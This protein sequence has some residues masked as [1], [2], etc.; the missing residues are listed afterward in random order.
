[1]LDG[2][3]QP[4]TIFLLGLG[5]GFAIPL[6]YRLGAFW[7]HAGF[8][9]A[10]A[11]MAAVSCLLLATVLQT[12]Q[13]IEVLTAG[14]GPPF[15][16][17]LRFG[18][19]EGF[20][21][22]GVNIVAVLGAIHL[23]G[24]L[25]GNY[26]ALLLYLILTMG[27]AGMVMTRDLFNLFV[28]LEIVSIATYGLLGLGSDPRALAAGFK[29]IAAT[30]VASS[31]FLLGSVLLYYATGTLN[32]DELIARRAELGGVTAQTG[33]LLLLACL[34]IELKPFP[35]N[36]WG[37]DAYETAPSGIAAMMSV[38]VSAGVFFALFKLLPIFESQYG[39]IALCGGITFL[40]SNLLGLAQ[41]KV[42]RLFG[43]SSV[44]QMGLL[45]LA[46]VLLVQIGADGSLPLVVGG[47]FLNHLLAKAGLFWFAGIVG[48]VDVDGLPRS[49]PG[50]RL[51]AACGICVISISG[52][53]PFPAFWAKW[54]LVLQLTAAD[55]LGWVALIL[56]GS[57]FEAAYMFRWFARIA[58]PA[59]TQAAQP[60]GW[61]DSLPV[62]LVAALL[63]AAGYGAARLSGAGEAWLMVP[64]AAGGALYALDGLPS[65]VKGVVTL[66]AVL[67]LGLWLAGATDGIA[68]LF[69]Y[70]LLA[71]SL[72]IS[73]GSL[74]RNDLRPGY[75][76]LLAVLILSIVALLRASTSLQFFYS[77][78]VVTLASYFLIAKGRR[79]GPHVLPFLLF[80]LASA[81]LVL[82]G[83]AEMAAASGGTELAR[84][85]TGGPPANIALFLL[86]AGF[87]IKTAAVG[88]HVWLAGAYAE[89]DDDVTAMLSAVVSKVAII[90]LFVG[91]YLA[92][93][94]AA[95]LDAA[96]WLAWIGMLTTIAGALMAL[97]QAD[98]KR[99]LAFSS[100]SQ[101][102]YI[103]TAIALM[104]HLGWVTA[105]Y[106][107]ANHLMVKGILFLAIAGI[108]LR[109]GTR[110]FAE[111]GGLRRD[112]PVTFAMVLVAILSM[113]GL[114]P[115]MGFGA[116]WLLL[117]AMTD[118]GWTML[119]AAGLFATFLGFLYMARL[120][121]GLFLGERRPGQARAGEAPP[122]L[123]LPQAI[124]I[125]G[126][127]VL[128]FFPKLLME[129][130]SRAIDPQFASTLVW[131]GMSLE[132]I[133]G[134]WNPIPA[135]IIATLAAAALF[136]LTWSIYR[137]YRGDGG[138]YLAFYRPFLARLTPGIADAFWRG[139]EKATLVTASVLRRI[140]TGNG[141]TYALHVMLYFLAIYLASEFSR[142][143]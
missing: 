6:F 21:V 61:L 8:I 99:M 127:V 111:V 38:G 104:S 19:W 141:Q 118:K 51:L 125:G 131:E 56:V 53:P 116:K 71:G 134:Y 22:V 81:F 2:I 102:G 25:R 83:F 103:V 124:L 84:F 57:L 12:G 78:E 86:A 95:G 15:S 115:L 77:W 43:Y 107:V 130:V 27:I 47:L 123:L 105:L 113:S 126:I 70:L 49:P 112:M 96:H 5:G 100:M 67:V 64:L 91:T 92:I 129:P 110:L 72:V 24:L 7:L 122:M 14:A 121:R 48:A 80:S 9:L 16:I 26:A 76:P 28:F 50:R 97:A 135:A 34:V 54:E 94:S 75:Y 45:V 93:R 128:S 42:Q 87:L 140:Y 106:L 65:R 117:S 35:A 66:A 90:G 85:A 58:R 4:L 31:Y 119:A 1:M 63:V 33:L 88:V 138:L 132:T 137:R 32:I 79:A 120:V 30:V 60:V 82:V 13:P 37:L 142:V 39:I 139:V 36:G 73:S 114:P 108:I 133:Y 74:Y 20:C 3:F 41:G 59:E 89:A 143:L 101:L 29:Y 17:N 109:T 55:R 46:L 62:L 52:L 98:F 44:G 136:A 23:R 18:P 69:A 10:L 40:F 68:R 11:G